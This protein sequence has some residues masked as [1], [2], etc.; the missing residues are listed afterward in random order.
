MSYFVT[1]ATGFIG[2]HLVERLL[3]REGDIHVLVR[4]GSVDKLD[5]PPRELGRSATTASS[6]SSATSPSRALGRLRRGPRGAAGRRPL[7]PP[8]GDLRHDRRRGA[9]RARST[10]AARGTPSTSPTRSRRASSTTSPRSRRPACTRATSP[11][12]CS[13][14]ARSSTH[15]YHRTKFESEK[16]ARERSTVPWRVY[17]PSIVVGHSQDRRDGQDRRPV[18]LL[19]G[20]PE[21]RATRCRRGSR[22]SASRS[23]DTNIVPVDYVAAAM[24]HIA[25]QPGLD[26]QAFHLV[27]PKPQ[28]AGDV[29]Q[30]V[31]R[32]PATRR[33]WRC[34]ST[35]RSPTCCRRASCATR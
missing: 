11:R 2:R 12:T 5:A 19:Q 15:P 10:S 1:G 21:G 9:Q 24:D 33:R 14:R 31:R 25:H 32:A 23:G 18:L 16:L 27:N 8:R 35:R 30:H 6:R 17:R 29:D 7:L 26:G 22:W 13:T 20:D 28:R 4:E 34:G 3:E